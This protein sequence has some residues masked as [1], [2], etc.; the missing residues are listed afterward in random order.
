MVLLAQEDWEGGRE[1]HKIT[2]G[3]M[4]LIA[5]LV[6]RMMLSTEDP[7]DS[8]SRWIGGCFNTLKTGGCARVCFLQQSRFIFLQRETG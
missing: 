6:S 7:V 2:R 5:A 8:T 4:G 1:A 3:D